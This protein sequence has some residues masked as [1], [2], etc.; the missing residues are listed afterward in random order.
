ML[1]LCFNVHRHWQKACGSR[2]RRLAA[3]VVF[4]CCLGVGSFAHR[5]PVKGWHRDIVIVL[6]CFDCAGKCWARV[7]V[8]QGQRISRVEVKVERHTVGWFLPCW[9]RSNLKLGTRLHQG[10]QQLFGPH[11]RVTCVFFGSYQKRCCVHPRRFWM[12]WRLRDISYQ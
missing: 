7:R 9:I 4:S 3:G 5:D 8:V 12:Y 1:N 2:R 10:F 6:T 11:L